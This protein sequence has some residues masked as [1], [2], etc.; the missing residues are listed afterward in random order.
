[1]H[2]ARPSAID[3]HVVRAKSRDFELKF[4]FQNNDHAKVR[5]DRVS[6]RKNLLH[7]FG[8]CV[9]RDIV[10]LRNQAANHVADTAARE[11][12]DV[13]APAQTRANLACRFFH[14]FHRG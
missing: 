3:I 13:T 6:A 7:N 12:R 10:I 5:A 9:R 1:M 8:R 14:R 11:V 4:V 2:R